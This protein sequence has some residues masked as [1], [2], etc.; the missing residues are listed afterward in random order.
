MYND[1][2]ENSTYK[3]E[4]YKRK[5][6]ESRS[7]L[8]IHKINSKLIKH[9][10][11]NKM[12]LSRI[13]PNR[14][15][16]LNDITIPEK[17]A[18]TT[19]LYKIHKDTDKLK[20][21]HK[22]HRKFRPK[23]YKINM[24]NI[25]KGYII[26]TGKNDSYKLEVVPVASLNIDLNILCWS[27]NKSLFAN[28]PIFKDRISKFRT[29]FFTSEKIDHLDFDCIK[30]INKN[31][32]NLRLLIYDMLYLSNYLLNGLGFINIE[33]QKDDKYP[34]DIVNHLIITS[35]DKINKLSRISFPYPKKDNE[36]T[37]YGTDWCN[38]CDKA[39]KLLEEHNKKYTYHNLD[40][41][42]ITKNELKEALE[43]TIIPIIF[44][45]EKKVGNFSDL[46]KY[47]SYMDK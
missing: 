44:N 18:K 34:Y 45:Y 9:T 3:Y 41:L 25:E 15:V 30:N 35:F 24:S 21:F 16:S 42:K 19:L 20:K 29:K 23:K 13:E 8:N 32:P 27:W 22:I 38:Y 43:T 7:N 11:D 46:R 2:H 14:V 4:K 5:Y 12:K 26:A 33:V 28:I 47:L 40:K 37:I 31:N 36:W 1:H 17:I 10:E 6:L 39:K